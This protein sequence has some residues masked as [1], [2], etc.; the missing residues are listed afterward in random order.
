MGFFSWLLKRKQKRDEKRIVDI[1]IQN[2]EKLRASMEEGLEIP[3]RFH[4]YPDMY[5]E[6]D[7]EN[8]REQRKQKKQ[9]KIQEKRSHFQGNVAKYLKDRCYFDEGV[10]IG[11][12]EVFEDYVDWAQKNGLNYCK[13]TQSFGAELRHVAKKKYSSIR[14][15]DNGKK[16]IY[17]GFG[18]RVFNDDFFL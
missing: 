17:R 18:I 5:V 15:P 12:E 6:R 7:Q 13:S 4:H 8:Q 2:I 9:R 16:T 14:D 3:I 1:A 11:N 10:E